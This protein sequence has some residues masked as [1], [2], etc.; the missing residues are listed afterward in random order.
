MILSDSAYNMSNFTLKSISITQAIGTFYVASIPA[1][2][3]LALVDILSR[4]MS[5]EG[6]QRVQREY[7]EDRGK[8]IAKYSAEDNA[9][10]PTSIIIATYPDKVRVEENGLAFGQLADGLDWRPMTQDEPFKIGEV[11]D[12]QHRLLGLKHAIETDGI[13]RLRDFELPVVFMLDLD[14]GDKAYVFSI[15]NSK[16]RSVSSSLIMDLFGLQEQRSPYKTCHEIAQAFY[17][18]ADDQNEGTAPPQGPFYKGLKMLGK[19]VADGEMLSQGSFGKYV[20]RLISKNPDEDARRLRENKIPLV[21]Y[22][23]CVLRY[24]FIDEKDFAIARILHE[25]FSAI[26]NEFHEEWD[27]EPEKYLLRKTV[28]F[29]ALITVFEKIWNKDIRKPDEAADYFAK[30]AVEF[31]KNLNGKP[32]TSDYFPS[33][34][35]G[36]SKIAAIMLN[37][38][39]PEEPV[40]PSGVN[41]K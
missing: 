37:G 8:Q 36:A 31:K 7:N 13:E 25:Y 14:Q 20:L 26:R 6:R 39:R 35:K 28:G 32:L 12:G 24:L 21:D 23:K 30:K 2:T 15:I 19:K 4:D 1:G 3:L 9:T 11:I 17:D 18:W 5:E 22:P 38:E 34:E 16:Q 10:F 29:S 40:T 27:V 33:S 41:N